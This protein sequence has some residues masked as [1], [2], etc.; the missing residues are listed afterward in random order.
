MAGRLV[1]PVPIILLTADA[2]NADLPWITKAPVWLLPKS[3]DPAVLAA[4]VRPLTDFTA[5]MRRLSAGTP[6]RVRR[7]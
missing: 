6:G 1:Y 7:R 3:I 5:A 4:A 2:L